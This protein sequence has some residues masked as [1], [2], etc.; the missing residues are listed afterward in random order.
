MEFQRVERLI[1]GKW[2]ETTGLNPKEY[3]YLC[4]TNSQG[5]RFLLSNLKQVGNEIK[6]TLNGYKTTDYIVCAISKSHLLLDTGANFIVCKKQ[7]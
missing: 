3:I 5:N 7:V 2:N 4:E 1:C 6:V